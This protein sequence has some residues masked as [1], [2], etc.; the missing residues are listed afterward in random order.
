MDFS[1]AYH[2]IWNA[3]EIL[4]SKDVLLI[5]DFYC[6]LMTLLPQAYLILTLVVDVYICDLHFLCFNAT[7]LIFMTLSHFE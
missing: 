6:I 1:H 5:F 3:G 4:S 2:Y 7:L